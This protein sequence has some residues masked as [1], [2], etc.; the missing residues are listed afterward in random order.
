LPSIG[1]LKLV[2]IDP[3]LCYSEPLCRFTGARQDGFCRIAAAE[4]VVI[5]QEQP[6]G[7]LVNV[8]NSPGVTRCLQELATIANEQGDYARAAAYPTESLA[9]AHSLADEWLYAISLQ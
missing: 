5:D 1:S 2:C 6:E 9:H 7:L 8:E 3:P 4:A